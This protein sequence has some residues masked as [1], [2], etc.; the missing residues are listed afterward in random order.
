MGRMPEEF[1]REF[2]ANDIE[3]LRAS[4]HASILDQEDVYTAALI[5]F[6]T[7]ALLFAGSEDPRHD[8]ARAIAAR[9]PNAEFLS[10]D[11]LD[12]LGAFTAIDKFLPQVTKFLDEVELGSR[13]T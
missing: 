5:E 4:Q 11:G 10:L 9:M 6:P 8:D 1:R 3:A 2:L 13:V 7:P 12:H